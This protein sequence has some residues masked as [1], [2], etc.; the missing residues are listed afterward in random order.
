MLKAA[1]L[2]M[3]VLLVAG[4]GGG[5]RAAAR[6]PCVSPKAARALAQVS[7]D[8]AALKR[9]A[10]L[11]TKNTLKG[12][13]AINRATDA[14]LQDLFTAPVSNL[15][16]NRMIDRAAASLVGACEQCFQALEASR[17]I[18]TIVHEQHQ[19]DCPK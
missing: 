12:N 3:A 15:T 7:R 14:F 10:A 17:P 6:K 11:P 1:L 9:A 16:R 19:G 2:V 18:V 4:C 5:G 8:V 13:P